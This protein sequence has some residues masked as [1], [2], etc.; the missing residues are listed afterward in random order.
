MKIVVFCALLATELSEFVACKQFTDVVFA[1]RAKSCIEDCSSARL[2]LKTLIC[3]FCL[4]QFFFDEAVSYVAQAKSFNFKLFI[5]TKFLFFSIRL[6]GGFLNFN[7]K[8]VM[9]ECYNLHGNF[10]PVRLFRFIHLLF[11][12]ISSYFILPSHPSTSVLLSVN[13]Q[14]LYFSTTT[15]FF[16]EVGC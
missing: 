4:F 5:M 2:W 10:V 14:N 6:C 1:S 12:F 11:K 16:K 8:L 7:F 9:I 15:I 13:L 3:C